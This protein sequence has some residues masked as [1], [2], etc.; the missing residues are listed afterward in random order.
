MPDRFAFLQLARGGPLFFCQK[1]DPENNQKRTQINHRLWTFPQGGHGQ[2]YGNQGRG[3]GDGN[4][5]GKTNPPKAHIVEGCCQA[6]GGYTRDQKYQNAPK[7]DLFL[8][9]GYKRERTEEEYGHEPHNQNTGDGRRRSQAVPGS[10]ISSREA[11]RGQEGKHLGNQNNIHMPL[12]QTIDFRTARCSHRVLVKERFSCKPEDVSKSTKI[13][14]IKVSDIE[15]Q[16]RLHS[17]ATT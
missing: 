15:N 17:A 5:P 8:S 14:I 1:D 16:K 9:E 2:N 13:G 7:L 4:R 12:S 10:H 11:E 6:R 3:S